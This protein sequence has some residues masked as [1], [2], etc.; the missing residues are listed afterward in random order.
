MKQY[1]ENFIEMMAVERASSRNTQYAYSKDL[2]Y[3][4]KYLEGRKINFMRVDQ[5]IIREYLKYI[6]KNGIK[7]NTSA[8]KLSSLRQF[9]KFLFQENILTHN[10]MN[11]IESPK[12]SK[13]LPKIISVNFIMQLIEHVKSEIDQNPS[14]LINNYRLQRFLSQIEILYSTGIRVSELLSIKLSHFNRSSSF[15]IVNGKGNK[16]RIVPL[17]ENAIREINQYIASLGNIY[18]LDNLVFLY[19][20]LGGKSTMT[21]QYFAKQLKL[22]SRAA[23][24]DPNQ[25]SPHVIRHAFASHMLSNGA[26]LRAVQQ[27]LGHSDISTTEIYT[28][29]LDEKLK[30][31]IKENHPLSKNM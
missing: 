19:P 22:Y 7:N 21:R 5:E 27:M 12:I 10:P 26:D 13:N 18:D 17:T 25:I 11:G 30:A 15:L 24:L 9:Y 14:D 29:I 28:H 8:R 23:G 1:I 31:T 4:C 6:N 2:Q 16:E 20:G 3:F